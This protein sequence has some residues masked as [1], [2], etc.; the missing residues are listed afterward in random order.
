MIGNDIVDL[1]LASAGERWKSQRFL[2]K[3]F[4]PNEQK[5]ISDAKNPFQMIWLFWSMKESAYKI[6]F[7]Q[8]LK[9]FF[10]P[11]KIVCRMHSETKGSV[12]LFNSLYR[13]STSITREYIYT[14]AF[15]DINGSLISACDK[16]PYADYITQHNESYRSAL[17]AFSNFKKVPID[18][19][20]ISKNEWGLPDLYINSIKKSIPL[21]ITHHGYYAGYAMLV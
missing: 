4:S 8:S 21:S 9:S 1:K 17:C 19:L 11:T 16:L 14:I 13:T 10:N 20:S 15:S 18:D 2:D 12:R 3:T 5:M 7:R 6:Y